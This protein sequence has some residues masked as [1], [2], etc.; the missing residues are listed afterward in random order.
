MNAATRTLETN[1]MTNCLSS[2]TPSRVA[3]MPPNT[4][5]SAATTAMGRYG[6][7]TSGTVGCSTT[8]DDAGEEGQD[9]NH[10]KP[11]AWVIIECLR[12]DWASRRGGRAVGTGPEPRAG[13]GRPGPGAEVQ[14]VLVGEVTDRLRRW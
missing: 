14:S 12:W 10:L 6:C 1:E 9:S 11:P 2:K 4:A 5:S 3:R 8:R 13:A 7:S